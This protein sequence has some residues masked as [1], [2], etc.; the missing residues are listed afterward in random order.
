MVNEFRL[1]LRVDM[2]K[3][4]RGVGTSITVKGETEEELWTNTRQAV[5]D[6]ANKLIE[7]LKEK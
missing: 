3:G 6:A 4:T 7:G 2:I 5:T 1:N